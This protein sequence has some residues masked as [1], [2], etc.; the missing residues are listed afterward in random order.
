M[1]SS[2]VDLN[3]INCYFKHLITD[4]HFRYSKLNTQY[5]PTF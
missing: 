1:T 2:K 5:F 3:T 4:T